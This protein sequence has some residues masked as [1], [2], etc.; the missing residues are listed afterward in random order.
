[1]PDSGGDCRRGL[2][3]TPGSAV[4]SAFAPI[5]ACFVR[6]RER[7]MGIGQLSTSVTNACAFM[8]A[9]AGRGRYRDAAETGAGVKPPHRRTI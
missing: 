4:F 5:A 6:T 7:F 2:M 8:L 9:N 3:V 1:M